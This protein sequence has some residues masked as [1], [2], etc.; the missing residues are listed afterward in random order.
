MY[1]ANKKSRYDVPFLLGYSYIV[2][3]KQN[4]NFNKNIH[5]DTYKNLSLLVLQSAKVKRKHLES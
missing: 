5:I 4:E 2:T 3:Y 1:C